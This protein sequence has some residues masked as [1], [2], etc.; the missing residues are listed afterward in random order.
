VKTLLMMGGLV[1]LSAC[2][3]ITSTP[4]A[5]YGRSDEAPQAD[6]WGYYN[7]GPLRW[8]GGLVNG[9]PHGSGLC[10]DTKIDAKR[11]VS[12]QYNAGVRIDD[13]HLAEHGRKIDSQREWDRAELREYM[14]QR[15]EREAT[16]RAE[17]RE[18]EAADRAALRAVVSGMA[19]QTQQ[20]EQE[21][22]A[23]N[24]RT[25]LLIA[26]AQRQQ[27]ETGASRPVPPT[28]PGGNA[29]AREGGRE[30]RQAPAD[31]KPLLTA[32]A[33]STAPPASASAVV[34]AVD[35]NPYDK[36]PAYDANWSDPA[37]PWNGIAGGEGKTRAEACTVVRTQKLGE[38]IQRVESQGKRKVTKS[39][40]CVCRNYIPRF[41]WVDFFTCQI[42][43]QIQVIQKGDGQTVDR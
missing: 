36:Y 21:R 30:N 24:A 18:S 20:L 40:D 26:Q 11:A 3:T 8:K 4:T 15:D 25:P 10:V 39:G 41:G 38:Y 9:A 12:C 33:K 31:P 19:A 28:Y 1:L 37:A 16:R 6:L 2:S 42:Y 13:A 7:F 34:E 35:A 43:V 22:L 5:S 14:A 17:R 23:S 27:M 32:Q 29:I